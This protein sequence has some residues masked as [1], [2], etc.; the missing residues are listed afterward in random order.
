MFPLQEAII[1][2]LKTAKNRRKGNKIT[3][4][5]VWKDME[6]VIAKII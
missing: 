3:L 4:P 2:T 6:T 5:L 1:I